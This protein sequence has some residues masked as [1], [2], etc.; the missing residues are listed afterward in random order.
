[1]KI[2]SGRINFKEICDDGIG[3]KRSMAR[4]PGQYQ[5]EIGMETTVERRTSQPNS[6]GSDDKV[7]QVKSRLI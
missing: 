3:R 1:V 2:E 5:N 7:R 4:E 6:R